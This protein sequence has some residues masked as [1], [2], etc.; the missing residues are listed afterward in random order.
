MQFLDLA[1]VQSLWNAIKAETAKS[2]TTVEGESA[3]ATN[4]YVSVDGAAVTGEGSDGHVNYVVALHNAASTTDVT[5]AINTLKGDATST[6]DTLGKLED[7]VESLET[8]ASVTITEVSSGLDAGILKAYEF[9]QNEWFCSY[10]W[11]FWSYRADAWG[12]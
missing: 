4:A 11:F 8:G 7:R 2:K 10:N 6:G 3:H 12:N 5:N 9:K 1:G